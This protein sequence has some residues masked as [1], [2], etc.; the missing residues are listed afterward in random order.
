MDE[1]FQKG[2]NNKDEGGIKGIDHE[3]EEIFLRAVATKIPCMC[4]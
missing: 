1:E 3:D 4:N 2:N